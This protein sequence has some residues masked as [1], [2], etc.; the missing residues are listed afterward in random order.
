VV[1]IEALGLSKRCVQ[2]LLL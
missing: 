1:L 2:V